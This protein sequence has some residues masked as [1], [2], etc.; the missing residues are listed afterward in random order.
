MLFIAEEYGPKNKPGKI[1]LKKDKERT[2]G[3]WIGGRKQTHIQ[4]LQGTTLMCNKNYIIAISRL[5]L[6]YFW[7]Y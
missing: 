4:N 1:S 5:V 7:P 2:V 3:K 6:N